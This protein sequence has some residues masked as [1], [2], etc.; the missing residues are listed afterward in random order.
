M[1]PRIDIG[2]DGGGTGCRVAIS[3]EGRV[4]KRPAARPMS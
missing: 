4:T 3:V 2:I 1:V